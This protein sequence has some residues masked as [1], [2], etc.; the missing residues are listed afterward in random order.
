MPANDLHHEVSTIETAI[1]LGLAMPAPVGSQTWLV[2][3]PEREGRGARS[4]RPLGIYPS[5][6]DATAALAE[7]AIRAWQVYPY[8]HHAPWYTLPRRDVS[9]GAF[10]YESPTT[11]EKLLAWTSAHPAEEICAMYAHLLNTSDDCDYPADVD[12]YIIAL[13]V[14]SSMGRG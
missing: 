4:T 5:R 2:R 1:A 9:T 8:S 11:Q 13:T 10:I 7:H 14:T 3:T 12:F 6:K